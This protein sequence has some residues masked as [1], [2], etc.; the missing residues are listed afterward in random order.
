MMTGRERFLIALN[1]GK[2]D[3][4]PCQVH[5]WM[6]YYLKTY[7]K[8]SDQFEAYDYF[9][10]DPVIYTGPNFMWN[11]KMLANWNTDYK[12]LGEDKNGCFHWHETITT[13][14]GVLTHKGSYNKFTGWETEHLIK[15]ENDFELWKEFAPMPVGIDWS[16]VRAA[17]ET[18]GDK[19]ITRGVFFDFGQGSPWQSFSTVLFGTEQAIMECYDKPDWVHYIMQTMLDKKLKV[20]EMADKIEL[21][22]VETGGGGGSSTVISPSFHKEFC[23]PYDKIQHT[24]LREKGTKS[25]YHLCGGLM[26]LLEIVAENGADGLETMT[27]KE[28]GGDCN[29][30]EATRQVGD[31]LFFIGGFDQNSGF[32]QGNPELI[33]KMV[34]DCHSKC[35]DGGYICSPSDHFFFGNPENIKAFVDAAKECTY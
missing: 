16:P 24:A 29:L 10:M 17:K 5:S 28:M 25:V 9:G 34:F 3:R 23:L 13:P 26:P 30:A 31:K 27:P 21:D 32:E 15:N 19:G 14:K 6:D 33:K 12:N 2:P 20:I 18:I 1:N 8:G 4:M 35:P 22:L 11:E 7:L